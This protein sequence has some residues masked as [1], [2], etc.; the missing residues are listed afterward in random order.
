MASSSAQ[1][2]ELNLSNLSASIKFVSESH[3]E[4]G[5]EKVQLLPVSLDLSGS[6]NPTNTHEAILNFGSS[7]DRGK[8]IGKD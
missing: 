8:E 6:I 7:A 1:K 2:P 4:G 5:L 3:M